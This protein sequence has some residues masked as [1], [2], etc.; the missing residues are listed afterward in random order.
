MKHLVFRELGDIRWES[1]PEPVLVDGR[2]ALVR[3]IAVA[4][5][6][7]DT[8]LV[9]G[10]VPL[11]GP[12]PL[13]HEFVAE[14]VEVGDEVRTLTVGQRVAVPFQ[15]S[16]GECERCR[17][18]LTGNCL[19]VAPRS[20]YG[21][22]VLGGLEWGGALADLVL[23]PFA[24]AMAVALPPGLDPAGVASISDNLPDAYR[25]VDRVDD[26][27]SVLVV[28]GGSIGLYAAGMA[29]ALGGAVTYVDTDGERLS[30][31]EQLGAKG[32][33]RRLDAP[34]G[35]F[36]LVVHTSADAEQ[37]A[38]ALRSTDHGGECVDTGIYF[39][40]A[41][42]LP[43]LDM[44]GTGL[45]FRTGRAHARRDIPAVLRLVTE[46]G[47]DPA[48]VTSRK[49]PWDAADAAFG[50]PTTKLVISRETA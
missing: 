18:G 40:G 8:A 47:F 10:R 31:A 6:D 5:C 22:G 2:A 19:A 23:V 38:N 44:Y 13:G 20:S 50:E 24:D 4:A 41:V 12:L 32:V 1:V 36:P 33:E 27:M 49:V 34:L 17:N 30:V 16:C 39:Q 21:L 48:L 3:P 45:T 43:M 46:V 11:P 7:L 26:G 9:Q 14:V 15:I 25:A 37:L 28:G 42:P 29:A 35:R